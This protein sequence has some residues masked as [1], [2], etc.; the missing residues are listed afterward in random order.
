MNNVTNLFQ[1]SL[2]CDFFLLYANEKSVSQAKNT[3]AR[4]KA[5]LL[6]LIYVFKSQLASVLCN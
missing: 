5:N 2:I 3:A 4:P 1:K 6:F